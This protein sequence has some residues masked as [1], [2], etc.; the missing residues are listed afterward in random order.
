MNILDFPA[1][2]RKHSGIFFYRAPRTP[3]DI[4]TAIT[5]TLNREIR[6]ARDT[7]V[8]T[9]PEVLS[10]ISAWVAKGCLP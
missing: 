10:D 9:P 4:C 2:R 8:N 1:P 6:I 7:G 5:N 3:S